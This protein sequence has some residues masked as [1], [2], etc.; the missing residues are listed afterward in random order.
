MN[1]SE[2]YSFAQCPRAQRIAQLNDKLRKTG[3]GGQTVV[4]RGVTSPDGFDAKSLILAL[5]QSDQFDEDNDT[6]GEHDFGDLDWCGAEL[7]W[8]RL[9]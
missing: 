9:L 8:N 7:L 2:Q 5:S 4:T 3:R 6:H 1:V